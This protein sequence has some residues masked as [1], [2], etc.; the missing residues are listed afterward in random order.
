MKAPI[1][2]LGLLNL[3]PLPKLGNFMI[4]Q[5]SKGA[6]VISIA[7]TFIGRSIDLRSKLKVCRPN[8]FGFSILFAGLVQCTYVGVVFFLLM[9]IFY[10]LFYRIWP[11]LFANQHF[12]LH[13]KFAGSFRP[14][15]KYVGS[16]CQGNN[17]P[18][19][20]RLIK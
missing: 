11:R 10:I 17:W 5:I 3:W 6:K 1:S 12:T 8:L 14:S 15:L 13:V 18:G 7:T 9:D 2:I 16:F 4:L 20:P 19:W